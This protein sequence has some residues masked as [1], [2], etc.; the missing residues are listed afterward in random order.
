M[1]TK[2]IAAT[3]TI[4]YSGD[5]VV[6]LIGMRINKWLSIRQLFPVFAAMPGMVREL[7]SDPQSGCRSVRTFV[8]GRTILNMTYWDNVG[9]LISYAQNNN[10]KH[11]PAWQAFNRRAGTSTAVGIFHETYTVPAGNYETL[12]RAMPPFGL[13]AA[14]DSLAPVSKR[15]VSARQRF[16]A[17]AE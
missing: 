1:P 4:D 10:K 5:V 14:T 3:M 2:P 12:Y 9:Q 15:G 17:P 16:T 7:L 6:F 8:S 11:Q 13:A